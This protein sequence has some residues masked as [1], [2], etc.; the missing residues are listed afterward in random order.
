MKKILTA[1]AFAAMAMIPSAANAW[2]ETGYYYPEQEPDS[3]WQDWQFFAKAD[4][5]WAGLNAGFFSYDTEVKKRVSKDPNVKKFQWAFVEWFASGADLIVEY[6]PDTKHFRI[7]VQRKGVNNLW[8]GE[9]FL[10]TGWR[11]FY[12]TDDPYSSWDEVNGI[13]NL[14]TM[15]YYPNQDNGDGTFGDKAYAFG[16][17][18]IQMQGFTKY[19]I[20][21]QA[22]ECVSSFDLKASL[23]MTPHPKNACY[24]L[25][26]D[27]VIPYDTTT[28][29]RVATDRRNPLDATK[30]V[31]LTLKEGVNS[32]V[33]ASYDGDGKLYHSVR[34]I[35]CMPEDAANWKS[36]GKGRFTE[37]AVL[38]LGGEWT[39]TTLDVEI[40]EHQTRAGFYRLVDP[41]K[42]LATKWKDLTYTHDEHR[43][44]M[45][46]DATNP[47]L[48][49]LGAT[50]P[51]I[52]V[53]DNLKD[54]YLTSKAYEMKRAGR[55][56]PEYAPYC[57]KLKDGKITFPSGA[58][59]VRLPEYTKTLGNDLVYWVNLNEAF[60]VELP[61]TNG[62]DTIG[63]AADE[64]AEYFT[65][66]GVRVAC[67]ADGEIVIVR[68]G[69]KV[70]KEM[71]RK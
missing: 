14:Y 9:P 51:G 2:D 11:E 3:I 21:I 1:A 42:D 39:P 8:D 24:E 19:D 45:Y 20:D 43:H 40:E 71:F 26:N 53:S 63:E 37:D 54:A 35:Y 52:F 27:L 17:N 64:E 59:G 13:L 4:I 44:Y 50:V 31:N 57:G 46:V 49:M 34:N 16:T 33:C 25:I 68:R 32:I 12:G 18:K 29:V 30:E 38:G 47:N 15:E 61:A 56:Q 58:V 5:E 55:L 60:A 69:G 62:V 28:F 6:D 23:V 36:L 65:L 10:L 22:P 48:V 41:Y 67:P 66:Q 7:P 70:S